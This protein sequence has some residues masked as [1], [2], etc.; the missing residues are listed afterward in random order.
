[1][2]TTDQLQAAYQRTGLQ[3]EG[4]TFDAAIADPMFKK[5]LQNLAK[6]A[7]QIKQPPL[8]KHKTAAH[9]QP[10]KD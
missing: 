3:R 10:F 8:P 9:W 2:Q 5:C 4:I 1:M 7:E 6:L